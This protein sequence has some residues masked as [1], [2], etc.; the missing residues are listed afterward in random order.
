MAEWSNR[1]HGSLC[2]HGHGSAEL[3]WWLSRWSWAMPSVLQRCRCPAAAVAHCQC[4]VPQRGLWARGAASLAA[5]PQARDVS[6]CPTA[7]PNELQG[8]IWDMLKDRDSAEA[9]SACEEEACD[10]VP[11]RPSCLDSVKLRASV[12]PPEPHIPGD[13]HTARL[14]PPPT[15]NPGCDAHPRKQRARCPKAECAPS[16]AVRKESTETCAEKQK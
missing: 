7:S 3:L 10:S 9:S 6:V 16:R 15:P 4:P 1:G 11:H 2:G 8:G 13:V 14:H 12:L 5:V